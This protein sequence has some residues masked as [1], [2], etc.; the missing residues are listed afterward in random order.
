MH[1]A[2]NFTFCLE[3]TRLRVRDTMRFIEMQAM[4]QINQ[5]LHFAG[6]LKGVAVQSN[7]LAGGQF[8][9]NL[10]FG[11]L[12]AVIAWRRKLTLL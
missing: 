4:L 6:S 11:Q 3:D 9:L 5:D 10:V 1:C 7:P 2:C 12:D 8:Y